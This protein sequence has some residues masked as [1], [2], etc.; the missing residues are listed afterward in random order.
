MVEGTGGGGTAQRSRSHWKISELS[1]FPFKKEVSGR[2][3]KPLR[4]LRLFH[5]SCRER[6]DFFFFFNFS[7]VLQV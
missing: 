5:P 2:E 3:R 4:R 1:L 6:A 7:E